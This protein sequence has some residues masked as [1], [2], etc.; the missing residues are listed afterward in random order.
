MHKAAVD[1]NISAGIDI[2][3]IRRGSATL[4][5]LR[6][7][8]LRRSKDVTVQIAHVVALIDV[9]GPERRIDKVHI[10]NG[11]ILTVGNIGQS[12][13]LCI[14]IGALGVPRATYPELLPKV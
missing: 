9:V 1:D 10:L 12:G 14:L 7:Y 4:R 13:A 8:I 5:I 2:D 3:S 6:P 11:H